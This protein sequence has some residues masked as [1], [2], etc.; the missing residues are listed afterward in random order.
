[1]VQDTYNEILKELR[2]KYKKQALTI[3]ETAQEIGTSTGTLRSGIKV[4]QNV[5]QFKS[6]G[7]GTVRKK[8]IFP[9]HNVAKFLADTQ[10]VF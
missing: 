6:I 7:L 8:Y 4:G 10:Q 5:P 3:Q 1:M 9:I 2:K